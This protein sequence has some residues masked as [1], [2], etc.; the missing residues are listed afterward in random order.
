MISPTTRSGQV[1]AQSVERR[2]SYNGQKALVRE[3]EFLIV[4]VFHRHLCV[5][6]GMH[7]GFG[8]APGNRGSHHPLVV[9]SAS[10]ASLREACRV[11]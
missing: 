6:R 8:I 4:S 10:S 9:P 2:R 5:T 3:A 11:L 7:S 1:F